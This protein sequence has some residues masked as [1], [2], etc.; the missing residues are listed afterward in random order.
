[1]NKKKRVIIVIGTHRSGSSA[2]T[3]G[4]TSMGVSL[5]DS[6]MEANPYNHKGHWEDLEFNEF[7][8]GLLDFLGNPN[9]R[10]R[11][12]N[13]EE[14]D[15][16]CQHDFFCKAS[17]LLIQ[18]ISD[19][20]IFGIKNPK[21][22]LLL[23]F[24]KKVFHANNAD[25]SFVITLRNPWNVA[26]SYRPYLGIKDQEVAFWSWISYL[27]SCLEHSLGYDR[28]IVEYQELLKDPAHQMQRVAHALRLT[29]NPE[30]LQEYCEEFIDPSLCHYQE[31]KKTLDNDCFYKKFAMEIYETLLLIAQDQTSFYDIGR[32][33]HQWKKQ[34]LQTDALLVMTERNNLKIG[35]LEDIIFKREQTIFNLGKMVNNQQYSIADYCK[36]LHQKNLQ[37]A[38]LEHHYEQCNQEIRLLTQQ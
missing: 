5:G 6:L 17:D 28:I 8:N 14:I 11:P 30:A 26:T 15:R 36:K 13:G 2:F 25:P 12:I 38:F 1:M 9:R 22:S 31:E 21:F 20:K 32:L 19:H 27:L 7:N 3:K 34:F 23:P 29:I 18:K 35:K 33:M 24:W 37:I 10:I 4:L 16:L